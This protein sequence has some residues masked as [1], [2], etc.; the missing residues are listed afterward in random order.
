MLHKR[1]LDEVINRVGK[2]FSAKDILIA[3]SHHSFLSVCA[4]PL[5]VVARVLI[6]MQLS[7]RVLYFVAY[8]EAFVTTYNVSIN[9]QQFIGQF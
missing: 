3:Q 6:W 9:F 2:T 7:G 4:F 5:P 1:F 8:L